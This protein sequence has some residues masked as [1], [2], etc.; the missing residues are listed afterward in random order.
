MITIL[1]RFQIPEFRAVYP[2]KSPEKSNE[3]S[4][5]LKQIFFIGGVLMTICYFRKNS[6]KL[7]DIK[8]EF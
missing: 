3:N 5:G 4:N 1:P 2:S 6:E 7:N 8:D